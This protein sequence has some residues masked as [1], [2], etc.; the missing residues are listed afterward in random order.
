MT[1]LD[2]F[3][4]IKEIMVKEFELDESIVTP[5][6]KLFENLELDS[7]DAVDLIVNLKPYMLDKKIDADM[8]RHVTTVQNVV[9][10]IYPLV[11]SV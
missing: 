9:D 8:F 5:E 10:I 1:K 3:E 6:A 7:I 11:S 4:K 2:V